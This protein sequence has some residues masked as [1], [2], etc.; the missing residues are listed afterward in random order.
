MKSAVAVPEGL[1]LVMCDV[2]CGSE[3]PGMVKKVLAWRKENYDESE[4]IWKGLQKRNEE[5]AA[6]LVRLGQSQH[7]DYST[8]RETIFAAHALISFWMSARMSL[9]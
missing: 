1:R 2:D 8:L 5:L 7:H 6:E 3:T 4:R 9:E